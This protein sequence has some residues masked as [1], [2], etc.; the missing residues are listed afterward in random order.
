MRYSASEKFEII[1]LVEQSSLQ[2]HVNR[3]GPEPRRSSCALRLR[4]H[5]HRL[6]MVAP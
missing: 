3:V 1:E 6:R 5:R 4:T 2:V